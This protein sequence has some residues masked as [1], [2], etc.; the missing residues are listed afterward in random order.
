MSLICPKCKST[1]IDQQRRMTG[2]IWCDDCG[3]RVEEKE[4]YNPFLERIQETIGAGKFLSLRNI[5][6]WEFVE[7]NNGNEVVNIIA[8]TENGILLVEQHR[9]A[10]N[11]SVISLPGGLVAD[12]DRNETVLKAAQKELLEETGYYSNDLVLLFGGPTS[13]GLTSEYVNFVLASH[14]RKKGD[15]GGIGDETILIHEVQP[16]CLHDWM[17]TQ[18][19]NGKLVSPRVYIGLYVLKCE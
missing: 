14:L 17:H 10:F 16:Q 5:D 11:R 4:K 6:N 2:P 12:E 1:N 18:I 3:Y 7:R 9:P 13:E 8:Q 19:K 15:G